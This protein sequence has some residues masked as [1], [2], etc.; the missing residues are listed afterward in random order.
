MPTRLSKSQERKILNDL[1]REPPCRWGY[2]EYLKVFESDSLSDVGCSDYLWKAHANRKHLP[3][4][5]DL[6]QIVWHETAA[7]ILLMVDLQFYIQRPTRGHASMPWYFG[8]MKGLLRS[9]D[10][11]I[12]GCLSTLRR[13]KLINFHWSKGAEEAPTVWGLPERIE[14]LYKYIDHANSC[15]SLWKPE[16]GE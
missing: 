15:P 6:Q 11:P 7:A 14:L 10:T 8:A 4:I 16:E 3:T 13:E 12:S 5:H 2:L 1:L 9:E